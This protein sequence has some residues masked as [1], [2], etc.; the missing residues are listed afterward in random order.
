MMINQWIW[1]DLEVAY[2]QKSC[3]SRRCRLVLLLPLY[4]AL[5]YN[6]QSL[7]PAYFAFLKTG[8]DQHDQT[9]ILPAYCQHIPSKLLQFSSCPSPKMLMAISSFQVV[10]R[11]LRHE[12]LISSMEI[13]LEVRL[14]FSLKWLCEE[15]LDFLQVLFFP[16]T[17][18]NFC[19]L[20]SLSLARYWG[21]GISNRVKLHSHLPPSL[22]PGDI[23]G[24][25]PMVINY[26]GSIRILCIIVFSCQ[27]NCQA[28]FSSPLGFKFTCFLLQVMNIVSVSDFEKRW[29]KSILSWLA[30]GRNRQSDETPKLREG[31]CLMF[32]R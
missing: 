27:A 23:V 29:Q 6:H 5:S 4:G 2:L 30:T 18:P 8:L 19:Q 10:H 9:N 24:M 11:V 26:I 1:N 32:V 14:R 7:S 15:N 3:I 20:K 21:A 22:A 25:S 28:S 12:P 13:R 17:K 31:E 16:F